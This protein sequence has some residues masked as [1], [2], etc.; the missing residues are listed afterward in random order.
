M[1]ALAASLSVKGSMG[2]PVDLRSIAQQ[3]PLESEGNR[4]ILD[5]SLFFYTINNFQKET[6][7]VP[8]GTTGLWVTRIPG[9]AR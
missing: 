2:A 9:L 4:S 1:Q 5:K 8:L 3:H 6:V 7:E